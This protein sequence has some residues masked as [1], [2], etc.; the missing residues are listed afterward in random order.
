M[1]TNTSNMQVET[2]DVA[3][4][5]QE[6]TAG[7]FILTHNGR[8]FEISPAAVA[9]IK[10]ISGI[11]KNIGS[12]NETRFDL[13]QITYPHPI[14][15]ERNLGKISTLAVEHF[16]EYLNYHAN[17]K[18]VVFYF[19]DATQTS[20][21]EIKAPM[22]THKIR[23][24][25]GDWVYNYF[26]RVLYHVGPNTEVD[27]SRPIRRVPSISVMELC[28]RP[29]G[30][31]T[32]LYR[33]Y[34][35]KFFPSHE[36]V[37]DE[38]LVEII[39][40][41]PSYTVLYQLM[42]LATLLNVENLTHLCCEIMAALMM[43]MEPEEMCYMFELSFNDL[44]ASPGEEKKANPQDY[45]HKK[46]PREY[47]RHNVPWDYDKGDQ[48]PVNPE[49]NDL[50]PFILAT[51]VDFPKFSREERVLKEVGE[52]ESD[53]DPEQETDEANPDLKNFT[54]YRENDD[55]C[56]DQEQVSVA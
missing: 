56:I 27:L 10:G 5:D 12:D 44:F 22:L 49:K 40:R 20:P 36:R 32:Y 15:T 47:A 52:D 13:S 53:S 55:D 8:S 38:Q 18:E 9:L 14:L 33:L 3:G 37:P 50:A 26:L 54:R 39:N 45:G 31:P 48:W 21:D 19:K 51:L 34:R 16:V 46:T 25:L 7:K 2:D 35:E 29:K 17:H 41:K 6:L 4:F 11:P 30:N 28:K 24:V 1:S 23:D 42:H 43:N